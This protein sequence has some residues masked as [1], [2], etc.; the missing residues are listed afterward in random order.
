[1]GE[2]E[3]FRK[4]CPD[5][6][7]YY[8]IND[9]EYAFYR[10][11]TPGAA[12]TIADVRRAFLLDRL[13]LPDTTVGK[14][15]G[16]LENEYIKSV[17]AAHFG[18]FFAGEPV[19]R[20]NYVGNPIPASDAGWLYQ[21]GTGEVS[22]TSHVSSGGPDGGPFLRRTITT[23]KTGGDS[24]FYRDEYNC[25]GVAGDTVTGSIWVR[26]SHAVDILCNVNA[27]MDGTAVSAADYPTYSLQPNVWTR[28]TDTDS[29]T[30]AFNNV[31]LWTTQSGV[32]I[33]PAG[34]T[35]DIALAS[36]EKQLGYGPI[37]RRNLL[38]N[39]SAEVDASTWVAARGT[40]AAS[41]LNP[42][43]G[44]KSLEVTVTD[45]SNSQYLINGAA[46]ADRAVVKG[47]KRVRASA[48][49]RLPIAGNI[50]LQLYE[51][52]AAGTLLGTSDG[53]SQAFSANVTQRISTV[54]PLRAETET[55][56][57]VVFTPT[58]ALAAKYYAD[59][60]VLED[61]DTATASSSYFDGRSVGA[62][63]EG[64]PDAST[65]ILRQYLSD[66]SKI[67]RYFDGNSP[68]ARWEG[69][70]NASRSIMDYDW[71]PA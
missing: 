33:L 43:S 13:G 1:M 71:Q 10:K 59:S 26:S 20:I 45:A 58:L 11:Y 55:V 16:D 54:L 51:Y 5:E 47:L 48:D 25:A 53:A 30:A 61:A 62:E 34:G 49:V 8:T 32:M 36:I 29:T 60:L 17:G 14:T 68:G 66:P 40:V 69:A 21:T 57:M 19:K 31:Q 44:T 38:K 28:I 46:L 4:A 24:G 12:G 67:T 22:A 27:R 63:W 65:S 9:L 42:T 41:T 70:V 23:A 6:P 7:S 39:P 52:D 50:F 56:R 2:Y 3:F 35:L 18:E 64:I 15:V 37:T